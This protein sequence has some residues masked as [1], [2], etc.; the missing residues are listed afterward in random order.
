MKKFTINIPENVNKLIHRL[1]DNGYSAYIVGGCVRDSI[2]GKTPHD[3]DICTSATPEAMLIIFKDFKVIETGI[4]HGTITVI[5]DK[6]S[7]EIT[8]YRIDGEYT[9]YR[10]PDSIIYTKN[11]IKD[12]LRRDFTINAIAYND[13]DGL[14]DPFNGIKD[15]KQKIIRCVGNPIDRFKEDALRILRA[16]RFKS[17]LEFS[18]DADTLDAMNLMARNLTKL[19]KERITTE[20]CKIIKG[21][22]MSVFITCSYIFSQI[23]P[24]IKDM[25]DFN[26]NNPYHSYTVYAHT[27]KALKNC[28]SEDL[29]TKLAVFFHDIGKPHCY[30]DSDDGFRHFKGHGKVSAELT[31]QIMTNMKFDNDTKHKVTEL[32]F[33]H[34][35]TIEVKPKHIKRWLNKI[36]EEQFRR[37]LDI[38]RADIK[39]QKL[40]YDKES[41]NKVNLIEN[42][43]NHILKEK[44]CFTLKDLAVNGKDLIDIGFSPSIK[45]GETLNTLLQKVINEELLNNKSILLDEALKLL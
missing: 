39:G 12:L 6:E 32:V 9:D 23:I 5:I 16:I 13:E 37:L 41:I 11:L 19:S 20:F 30:Q 22:N 29:I 40:H 43:L 44:E 42:M 17:Q 26:Q 8:T 3:W 14:I 7:Y 36:G 25:I 45:L 27:I 34:D 1:Q 10:R 4:K 38:R 24:E 15:I 21:K 18:I 31:E 33:Y 28:E 2:L 35:S